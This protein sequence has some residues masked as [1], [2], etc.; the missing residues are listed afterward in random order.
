MTDRLEEL[1]LDDL[2]IAEVGTQ[3]TVEITEAIRN[4]KVSLS[5]TM[6]SQVTFDVF[7]ANFEMLKI[8]IFRYVAP[9]LIRG[10]SMRSRL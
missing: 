2:S 9:C 1:S 5:A 4:L 10:T 8:I 3:R 6:V 7:D